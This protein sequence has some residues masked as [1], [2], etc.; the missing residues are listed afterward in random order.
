MFRLGFKKEENLLDRDACILSA[1][2]KANPRDLENYNNMLYFV[3]G[4]QNG[5]AAVMFLKAYPDAYREDEVAKEVI[6]RFISHNHGTAYAKHAEALSL[7]SMKKEMFS[8]DFSV[9]L[10]HAIA[11]KNRYLKEAEQCRIAKEQSRAGFLSAGYLMHLEDLEKKSL[12]N[13]GALEVKLGNLGGKLIESEFKDAIWEYEKLAS[14]QDKEDALISKAESVA[15]KASLGLASPA[16]F[17]AVNRKLTKQGFKN[18]TIES[19]YNAI[20]FETE[21]GATNLSPTQVRDVFGKMGSLE[22]ISEKGVEC[23][24]LG[25]TLIASQEDFISE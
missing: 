3:E 13:C 18:P 8:G 9:D 5:K 1:R 24:E 11:Q 15:I 6:D 25:Q 20:A 22:D 12:E 10:M 23:I 4:S 17:M 21:L 2:A 19:Q 14:M 16:E 7:Y